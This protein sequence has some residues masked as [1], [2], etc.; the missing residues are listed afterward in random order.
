[1]VTGSEAQRQ[2]AAM[3]VTDDDVLGVVSGLPWSE[4][5]AA[6]VAEVLDGAL[7]AR[8]AGRV[9]AA[10]V[11]RGE[12]RSRVLDGRRLYS[13]AGAPAG[14]VRGH[15]PFVPEARRQEAAKLEADVLAAVRSVQGRWWKAHEVAD[16][17]EGAA[18]QMVGRVL[19]RLCGRGLVRS[20]VLDGVRRYR[21]VRMAERLA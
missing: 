7:S 3:T 14:A 16:V 2:A 11:E 21:A 13:S 15:G 20:R 10:A 17:V 12:L 9:L 4:Y 5:T 8:A 6:E 19:V 1:M 18:P